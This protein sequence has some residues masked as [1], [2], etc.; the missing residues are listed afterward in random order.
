MNPITMSAKAATATAPVPLASAADK[1][2]VRELAG[3]TFAI[4]GK[5][6]S[7]RM[8]GV[9]RVGYEMAIALVRSVPDG[10]DLPLFVPADARDDVAWP[11]AASVTSPEGIAAR[12]MKR[13]FKGALWEQ[14]VLP[15][16]SGGRTLLSLCNIGP[17]LARRQVLMVHDVAVYDLP[18]N[19]SWKYRLWYRVAYAVLKRTAKHIVTV[20]EFS[21]QRI[22]VRLGIDAS[23]I[24]VVRNGVDHFDRIV[25]DARILARLGLKEDGYVLIVGSLSVGKNLARV[26]AAVEQLSE[27][28]HDWQFV[29]AGGCDLRVFNGKAKAGLQPSDHVIAAGFVSDGELKALY[30][31]AGCF[32]FPSLYEGFGLPPL[33]AM[34]CGCPVIASRE[35]S[36]PEVCGD[37]AMYCDARS[38][39]DIARK[40]ARMM[41]DKA[42]RETWR[43]RGR[44]HAKRF[45]WDAAAREL[46]DVL[47]R[48]ASVHARRD[49]AAR[50]RI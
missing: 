21:K 47:E 16:A 36:L 48:E 6:A 28:D 20:S 31:H 25:P 13:V 35:A 4:N 37:A 34:S 30:E 38:V 14:L 10:A 8:T 12:W 50:G 42:L 22:M 7:Q 41:S 5:F 44:E 1:P 46:L 3:G 2:H 18:E 23:R 24:S 9:Q 40:I 19:Y 43:A 32:V 26:L 33:E 39:E 17:L 15:F 27:R 29:V 49:R 45:R 11:A